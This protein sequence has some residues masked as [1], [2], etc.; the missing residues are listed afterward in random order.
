MHAIILSMVLAVSSFAGDKLLIE[1]KDGTTW[2]KLY[3]SGKEWR[4]ETELTKHFYIANRPGALALLPLQKGS[5][6]SCEEK[7][8][9]VTHEPKQTWTGCAADPAVKEF[10]RQLARDCGR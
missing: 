3:S 2:T 9:V 6:D 5:E 1:A 4:C 8:S 7:I 10:R